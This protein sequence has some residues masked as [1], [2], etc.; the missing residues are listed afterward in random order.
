ME[1]SSPLYSLK[2]LKTICPQK[3]S[4]LEYFAPNLEDENDEQGGHSYHNLITVNVRC[5]GMKI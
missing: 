3:Y 2:N 1:T 4:H 5:I